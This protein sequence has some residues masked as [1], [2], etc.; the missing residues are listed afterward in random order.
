MFEW[1]DRFACLC[2]CVWVW[3][4]VFPHKYECVVGMECVQK[5][6]QIGFEEDRRLVS[7][8]VVVCVCVSVCCCLLLSVVVCVCYSVC[9]VGMSVFLSVCLEEDEQDEEHFVWWL[10]LVG[11]SVIGQCS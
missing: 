5:P 7:V 9:I 1:V 2:V 4:C 6:R 8:P 11:E 10:T 3:A